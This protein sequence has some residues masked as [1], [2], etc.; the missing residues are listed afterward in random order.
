VEGGKIKEKGGERGPVTGPRPL[1]LTW[2]H[3]PT[4]PCTH[5]RLDRRRL[6]DYALARGELEKDGAVQRLTGG[7]FAGG[8][9]ATAGL[10]RV[11][12][13]EECP[14]ARPGRVRCLRDA[15]SSV[16]RQLLPRRRSRPSDDGGALRR[17]WEARKRALERVGDGEQDREEREGE[18]RRGRAQLGS[19]T[20]R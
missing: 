10:R 19:P 7:D 8:L 14:G 2:P 1:G 18:G 20:S 16:S 17:T 9:G 5:D 15:N 11:A 12:A 13:H 3:G 6:R 4:W